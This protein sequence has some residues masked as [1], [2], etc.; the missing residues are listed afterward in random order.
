MIT[1]LVK[2]QKDFFSSGSTKDLK[3]RK[4]Y[5]KKLQKALTYYE[6]Q[7]CDT[8]YEDFK[9]P[10]FES[11]ASE[12]QFVLFELKEALKNIDSWSRPKRVSGTWINFP[13]SD[14]IYSEPYG[15]VLIM[16][17]WNYPFLL[18]LS[19]L[20][21]A[22]AAG[23]TAILKPSEFTPATSGII[24]KIIAEIFPEEYVTVIEGGI[25]ESQELLSQ[26]FDYIFFTGSTKVGKIVYQKAAENLTP[27]TLELGGKSPCII[28]NTVSI[29]VTAKRIAWGKFLNC[30]QTCIAPD[31]LLVHK[32]VKTKLVEALI[33]SIKELYGNS[34]QE[35]PD[36]ARIAHNSHYNTLKE[37]LIGEQLLF[38]GDFNDKTLFISPALVD[39]PDLKSKIM[40]DEIFGPL[41]PIISYDSEEDIKK[42]LSHYGK[43]LA[44]YIFSKN[45][46]FRERLLNGY[47]FGG[48][49]INDTLLHI[50]NSKLP[51]G[52][53]GASGVGH[54]QGKY[55]FESFSHQ[56]S[57]IKKRFWPEIPFRYAPYKVTEKIA[58]KLKYLFN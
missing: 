36:L 48:G 55:S 50:T 51:F 25:K 35:S 32:D 33:K 52:G 49:V 20:I 31:Y 30:G 6:D 40:E 26:K 57:I 58:K 5:L 41:L 3:F 21:G 22:L 29:P 37:M 19:P 17:P 46:K 54:Y 44:L 15:N 43:P 4:T 24:T 13:S 28:D 42:H 45:K 39:E 53:V 16:A 8:L 27:V 11:L 23:N 9:K 56:K 47:S 38:G 1:S 34:P 12:T 7:I 2:K 10:K 18:S 14:W